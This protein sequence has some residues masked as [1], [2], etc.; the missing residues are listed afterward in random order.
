MSPGMEWRIEL[1]DR[2]RLMAI[3]QKHESSAMT[4]KEWLQ[5][6]RRRRVLMASVASTI[7]VIA[8]LIA[9]LWPSKYTSTG[10]IL[11]EQQELPAELVR[12]T[13]TSFA[14]QR[15]QVISQRVMTTENLFK[16][17]Q[18]FDLY[19][20]ER[21]T[22]TREYV[23]QKM[24]DDVGFSMVSANVIDP[25]SG[26]PTK[27][28]IAFTVSYEN[29]S[30]ALASKVANELV[31]LY[32]Q[33]NIDSRK[34]RSSDA[35]SFLSSESR[36]LDKEII[37]QQAALEK[38]KQAHLNDLPEKTQLTV[39]FMD[40]SEQELRDI[41]LR[42]SAL[43]Q[44]IVYLES[45]LVQINPTA[46]VYTST[47]ERIMAPADRLK[48]LRTELARVKGVYGA[49]HPDV[50]RMQR[51]VAGLEATVKEKVSVTDLQRQLDDA[52][53]KL[54]AAQQKYSADHP[55]VIKL[56]RT[57]SSLQ[58]QLQLASRQP[59]AVEVSDESAD[60]PAYVQIKTQREASVLERDSLIQ[61]KADTKAKIAE[62][63]SRL[64]SGPEVER[65]YATLTRDLE[66]TQ[67]KYREVHQKEME[68]E[69]AENLE[70]ER[71]GERFTLI[72]P[73][74]VPEMPTSPN[75]VA[76]VVIGLL[77]SLGAG[78]GSAVGKESLDASVRNRRDLENLLGVAPLAV[79]PWLENDGEKA[80]H[81][82][83]KR[84]TLLYASV[85]LVVALLLTH[86][87]YRPLDVLW[88]IL[89]RRLGG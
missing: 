7:A 39:Q 4:L 14:D 25:R 51:E 36:R 84:K 30:P 89:M 42:I 74:S 31:S 5:V 67:L 17:I 77:L 11:I 70:T 13:I 49:G 33:Q 37:A 59:E 69:V 45:Q 75:R 26:N 54:A 68:A 6:F 73:P 29:R 44:Q 8:L 2:G 24:R 47:G 83:R 15:I 79:I 86:F 34:E 78:V 12:S 80:L 88:H 18:Q 60:N 71:K 52:N 61:K 62:Y 53:T 19:S 76:I 48:H 46:Q 56:Q 50:I 32:L 38:F 81:K 43:N 66:N 9:F 65:Q 55:D 57:I 58:S 72:E 16:I 87:F 41:D 10:T 63:Q 40:R 82:A 20:D 64:S 23:L 27:A 28:T 3:N 21:K 35:T 1:I 22:N 85:G